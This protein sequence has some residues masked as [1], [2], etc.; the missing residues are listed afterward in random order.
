MANPS[1]YTEQLVTVTEALELSKTHTV[2][3][4]DPD[5]LVCQAAVLEAAPGGVRILCHGQDAVWPSSAWLTLRAVPDEKP[6]P[7]TFQPI[8]LGFRDL[9]DDE[10]AQRRVAAR[11]D[12][13]KV[14]DLGTHDQYEEYLVYRDDLEEEAIIR[15]FAV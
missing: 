7:L 8:A 3:L 15:G 11:K 4:P 6:L 1:A 13:R 5:T 12:Q 14:R 2:W 10:L 9:S